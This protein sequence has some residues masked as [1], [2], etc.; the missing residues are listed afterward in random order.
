MIFY[1][2]VNNVYT[3]NRSKYTGEKS[4][5]MQPV[6]STGMLSIVLD[7]SRL[8]NIEEKFV[9]NFTWKNVN[10][11]YCYW[12]FF[13]RLRILKER[14]SNVFNKIKQID[15]QIHEQ[16]KELDEYRINRNKYQQDLQQIQTLKSRISMIQKK[17]VDLQNERTSIEKIQESSA[18]EI[19]VLLNIK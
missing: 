7:K 11:M 18:N 14:K 12:N 16:N 9:N 1:F 8:L 15:E 5:G 13:F 2:L 3:V 4:I 6:S 19:K 10:W 17:I